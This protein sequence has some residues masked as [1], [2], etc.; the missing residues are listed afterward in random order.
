MARAADTHA[1]LRQ[2]RLRQSEALAAAQKAHRGLRKARR[3]IEKTTRKLLELEV[4]HA[5]IAP[6]HRANE[7]RREARAEP[8][9]LF[10][11]A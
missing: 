3:A 4:N 2:K 11:E 6:A 8:L 1:A 7:T 5:R 10:G 9:P